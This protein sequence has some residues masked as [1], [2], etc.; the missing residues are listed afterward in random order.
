MKP[1]AETDEMSFA[2]YSK[3][4]FEIVDYQFYAFSQLPRIGFR[5]P[6]LSEAVLA[7]GDY[8]TVIGAAQSLGVYVPEPYP[9]L[10]SQRIGLP[11][12]NLSLGG[13]NPGFYADQPFLLELV[14]RGR[15]AILQVMTAR[16][17]PNERM[18]PVGISLVRD[19]V[20]GDVDIP[21]AVWQ[22]VLDEERHRAPLYVEQNLASWREANQ[23]L[24]AQIGVPVI[25]FYFSYKPDDERIDFNATTYEGLYGS[26]PQFVGIDDVRALAA[27][28]D[29][30]AEC[31][32]RR[33]FGHEIISRFTGKP[34]E[35]N[36]A[37]LHPSAT[38]RTQRNYYYPSPEMHRDAVAPLEQAI[39]EKG[40][41]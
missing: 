26:F 14:N 28:C 12:L 3:R 19:K 32:S 37:D 4:D 6:P 20:R 9:D 8:F 21:E 11:A 16:T 34:V 17:E 23:R 24:L 36:F 25:L 35:I 10:L 29:G 33:D 39:R 27:G 1:E 15:F 7:G 38:E 31:R 30:F 22:R 40:L 41:I 5:G 18:A 13:V 2:D